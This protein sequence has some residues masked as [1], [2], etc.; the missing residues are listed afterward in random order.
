MGTEPKDWKV[1][2]HWTK[3]QMSF[4][5][6]FYEWVLLS[7]WWWPS[8]YNPSAPVYLE[9][10]AGLKF[11]LVWRKY[12]KEKEIAEVIPGLGTVKQGRWLNNRLSVSGT[13]LRETLGLLEEYFA[14]FLMLQLFR[15]LPRVVLTP[16]IKL[17]YLLPHNYIFLLLWI[18]IWIYDM[19]DI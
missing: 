7:C 13:K 12:L 6:I 15:K 18:I 11:I 4:K 19:R 1:P 14:T 9:S 5:K 10:Q 16:T 17:W 8:I 2:Y 3:S